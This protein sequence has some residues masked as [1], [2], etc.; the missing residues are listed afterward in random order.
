MSVF[1]EIM[2]PFISSSFYSVKIKIMCV[3]NKV[4]FL[5]LIFVFFYKNLKNKI[6]TQNVENFNV[7]SNVRKQKRNSFLQKRRQERRKILFSS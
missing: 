5:L 3:L 1:L 7:M 6:K 4:K 2:F